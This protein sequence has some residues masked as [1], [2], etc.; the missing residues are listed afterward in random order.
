MKQYWL[1]QECAGCQ[2]PP[3][4][5]CDGCRAELHSVL[6]ESPN[7]FHRVSRPALLNGPGEGLAV[8]HYGGLSQRLI[9]EFKLSGSIAVGKALAEPLARL[10]AEAL[11]QLYS[12]DARAIVLVPAPSS[13]SAT[14]LR[15]FAP[16]E[17]LASLVARRARSLGV[18]VRVVPAVRFRL[19]VR[20]QSMLSKA[21]RA[22]NVAGSMQLIERRKALLANASVLL[23]DDIV[24]SGATLGELRHCLLAAG[25][26]PSG[27]LCFAETL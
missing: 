6:G 18:P 11:A 4:P 15:G 17:L 26:Q 5:I 10:L 3:K 24:T 21:E 13:R 12:D 20:D 23:F 1:P 27:F 7:G 25:I 2:E 16:A 14:R 22:E 19:A 9:H 8:T